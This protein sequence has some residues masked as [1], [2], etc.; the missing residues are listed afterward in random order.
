MDAG[1]S[2]GRAPVCG[3]APRT[4]VRAQILVRVWSAQRC[5]TFTIAAQPWR[6]KG[7]KLLRF[8]AFALVGEVGLHSLARKKPG[9]QISSPPPSNSLSILSRGGKS[10]TRRPD[11]GDPTRRTRCNATLLVRVVFLPPRVNLGVRLVTKPICRRSFTELLGG[12]VSH[13]LSF[14]PS[15]S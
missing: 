11:V 10:G 3:S 7:L 8:G 4:S 5:E 1:G 9:V 6:V 14:V 15:F 12:T 13:G 2:G